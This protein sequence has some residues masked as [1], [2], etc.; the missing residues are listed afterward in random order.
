MKK[1]FTLLVALLGASMTFSQS[2]QRHLMHDGIE[3]DYLLYQPAVYNGSVA[4]PLV[5]N[6]HGYTSNALQQEFYSNFA[7]IA[8]T[9]NFI[10][11]HP[12]GTTDAGGTTFWNA[13][14][15][16]TETVDDIG[17]LSALIDTVAASHNID[18]NR[19]YFTGMSNGG[20]MSYALA[21]QLSHRVA[22]IASVTGTMMQSSIN[23]CNAQHPMPVMQIHG[24]ADP[25]VPYAGNAQGFTAI[26]D[27]VDYWVSFNNCNTTP[28]QTALP[29]IAPMDGC[30][31]DHFLY[32]D[33]DA[34][35]SVELY[36]VNGGGHTWPG[37]AIT[38]GV[39]SQDFSASKEIWRFFSQYQLADLVGIEET[40]PSRSF[41]AYP[42]PS[43]GKVTLQFETAENRSIVIYSA[44]GQRVGALNTNLKTVDLN[45]NDAG[46]YVLSVME[47]QQTSSQ[48]LVVH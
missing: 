30:T 20:F 22:A 16:P 25:T 37:A 9:A 47:Q 10:L 32:A 43:N 17:F 27:V 48:K 26:E 8:D 1:V 46:V 44:V 29:D 31:T 36:R 35:A 13:F 33:G 12:D 11:V 2:V 42:N 38:I 41:A 7:P 3:R 34:G 23:T 45:I 21:C 40:Q 4:V 24:T 15:A 6:L 14:N 28:T 5:I 18:L 39:T 19:V